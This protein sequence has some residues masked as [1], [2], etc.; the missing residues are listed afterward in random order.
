MAYFAGAS[1][2]LRMMRS[3]PGEN[4]PY[5]V[6]A[7]LVTALLMFNFGWFREQFCVIMCPYGRFQSVLM[8]PNTIT[9]MYDE[10][11]GEPRRIG[12]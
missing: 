6:S 10:K 9:V 3:P 4:W 1:D 11:R 8:D 5:F 7:S 12:L 2:L